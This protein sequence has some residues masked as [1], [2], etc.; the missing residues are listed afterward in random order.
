MVV[1]DLTIDD[2]AVELCRTAFS[3]PPIP[4]LEFANL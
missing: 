4:L 3:L 1:V 2:V